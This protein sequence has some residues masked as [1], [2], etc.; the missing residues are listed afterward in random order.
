MT[1][2]YLNICL[3]SRVFIPGYNGSMNRKNFSAAGLA[4]GLAIAL[5]WG[6]SFVSIK[7]SVAVIPPLTLGLIR[8]TLAT[9]LLF[10]LKTFLAPGEKIRLQDLPWV[11]AAG[12]T[13]VTVYFFMENNGVLLTSASEASLVVG[14]IP[15]ATLLVEALILRRPLRLFQILGALLSTLGVWLLVSGALEFRSG[16]QGY[17]YMAGA[18]LS[19]VV[20]SFLS[21]KLFSAYNRLTVVFWQSLAGTLGFIPLALMEIPAWQPVP[22]EVWGHVAF[23]AVFCS[24]LGYWF[25]SVAVHRLGVTG[26]SLFVNLIPVIASSAGVIFLKEALSPVQ[27]VGA[28]ATVAG[29]FLATLIGS[30]SAKEI[31]PES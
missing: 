17:L 12:L 22:A 15:V 7:V 14:T 9:G 18:A 20:Y 29:V 10:F 2:F 11:G 21:R 31:P 24:A 19:W 8:F 1:L 23:L 3:V 16:A 4:A 25:Y 13:G 26:S 5:F 27:W 6:L 30:P 28:A